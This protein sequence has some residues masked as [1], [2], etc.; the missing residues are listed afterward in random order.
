MLRTIKSYHCA[1][2]LII[3][4]STGLL[5]ACGGS[6]GT[7]DNSTNGGTPTSG[8]GPT[9]GST[10]TK[11][12]KWLAVVLD[13]ATGKY[14]AKS[15]IP[16]VCIKGGDV[17]LGGPVDNCP[18]PHLHHEISIF[19][20]NGVSGPFSDP[21]APACGHGKI[22]LYAKSD[23][24]EEP[25]AKPEEKKPLCPKLE[26]AK[27]ANE[28]LAINV[29]DPKSYSAIVLELFADDGTTETVDIKQ[30]LNAGVNTLYPTADPKYTRIGLSTV[31]DGGIN[32]TTGVNQ[33]KIEKR[34]FDPSTVQQV[35]YNLRDHGT[36]A[37]KP[38][39]QVTVNLGDYTSGA[40]YV[41][42]RKTGPLSLTQ[43][44]NI[45]DVMLR[46]TVAYALVIGYDSKWVAGTFM[47]PNTASTIDAN[48]S[49]LTEMK[50]S[51]LDDSSLIGVSDYLKTQIFAKG[52]GM[53]QPYI[54]L[55]GASAGIRDFP[56]AD[57]SAFKG[58]NA[59]KS[60]FSHTDSMTN[61]IQS[62]TYSY[63]FD[64][65]GTFK[66]MQPAYLT[67]GEISTQD[68]A[69]GFDLTNNHAFS[70]PSIKAF[71]MSLNAKTMDIP[72]NI[73]YSWKW[74][75]SSSYNFLNTKIPVTFPSQVVYAA[76]KFG[77]YTVPMLTGTDMTK[78]SLD[79]A[80]DVGAALGHEFNDD[81]DSLSNLNGTYQARLNLKF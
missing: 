45:F 76:G 53:Y 52:G 68:T 19:D 30:H 81:S 32:S 63:Y 13:H 38:T 69:N 41:G 12:E 42:G 47:V 79:G 40:F 48:S 56:T 37:S 57:L 24:Y 28:P 73:E 11:T 34:E 66:P 54:D 77:T 65:P 75:L 18:V 71:M 59:L 1:S 5:V 17:G 20:Q 21:D 78:L 23:L 70:D 3:L 36:T 44:P 33:V 46:A 7:P 60:S 2:L 72:N 58:V 27:P 14:P 62:A 9:S 49:N 22:G 29:T 25:A 50:D 16:L 51:T 67:P 39:T 4:F 43:G 8:S 74:E 26:S 6:S 55:V 64:M 15:K 10:A 31:Y 35:L 61:I 80:S